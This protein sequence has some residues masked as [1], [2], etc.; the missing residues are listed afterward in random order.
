MYKNRGL[1]SWGR[2]TRRSGYRKK[3]GINP[4]V[5]YIIFVGVL[6]IAAKIAGNLMTPPRVEKDKDYDDLRKKAVINDIS[7]SEAY[8]RG[9]DIINY[10]WDY[11]PSKNGKVTNEEIALPAY[12]KNEKV[13]RVTGLPYCWGGYISIDIS[14]KEGVKNFQ[15]AISKGYVSG[16]V[17]TEGGYKE[18][19]AGLDC[20]G[21]VSAV[22]KLP[23]KCSTQTL[24][25]YFDVIDIKDIKPMDIFNIE[26]KHTFIFLRETPDK[27]GIITMEAT[28]SKYASTKDKT[29]INYRS[30]E[31]VK[32]GVD[33]EGY[34]PMRFRGVKD[35]EVNIFND[36]NEF[37]DTM[38]RA[39]KVK[40]FDM[41]KGAIDYVDD[42]D[43]FKLA[44]DKDREVNINMM[45]IPNLVTATLID[46][47]G[48]I[49]EALKDR[50]TY[51]I[52]LKK[53]DYYI[54]VSGKDFKFSPGEEYIF[55]IG[56]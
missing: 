36:V 49:V 42:V 32:K 45:A 30:W 5:V 39:S 34:T 33:G 1:K 17:F 27:K 23:E 18:Y 25:Y 2:R 56:N 15:D 55:Y 46:K 53:G 51:S 13:Q 14:N 54:K 20:S 47:D 37:N 11:V 52:K 29:V 35:D 9:M 8:K 12:L 26:K 16:N 31:D 44:V 41:Y 43:Y 3:W 4:I 10:V 28:T 22:Y 21:F 7:R 6:I 19:T 40:Y 48:Q 24:K 50:N 38:Q